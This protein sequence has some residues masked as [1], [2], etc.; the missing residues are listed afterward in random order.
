MGQAVFEKA[1]LLAAYF[2]NAKG[3]QHEELQTSTGT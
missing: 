3:Q 2:D 1:G